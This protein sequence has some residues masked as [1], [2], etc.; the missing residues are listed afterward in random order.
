MPQHPLTVNVNDQLTIDAESWQ[1][2]VEEDRKPYRTSSPPR[3]TMYRQTLSYLE[4][5]TG[6]QKAPQKS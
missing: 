6:Y 1:E 4:E 5:A 3:M 2:C